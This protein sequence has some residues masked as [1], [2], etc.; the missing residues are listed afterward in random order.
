MIKSKKDVKNLVES[1]KVGE[2]PS[3]V[4]THKSSELNLPDI[5]EYNF[6]FET[7]T[8]HC[9]IRYELDVKKFYI[10]YWGVGWDQAIEEIEEIELIERLYESRKF[11][12]EQIKRDKEEITKH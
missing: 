5:T 1:V 2:K 10:R 6:T 8:G 3:Y 7:E 11:V 12:N 4:I 9:N